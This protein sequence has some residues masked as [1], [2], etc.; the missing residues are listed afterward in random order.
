LI[1][2]WIIAVVVSVVI[3]ALAGFLGGFFG[4]GGGVIL[5]PA[6]LWLFGW[7]DPAA[8]STIKE[9]IGTSLFLVIPAGLGAVRK[10]RAL[11]NLELRFCTRWA[12]Y[13][14]VGAV[15]GIGLSLLFHPG[16]IKTIFTVYLLLCVI[17]MLVLKEKPGHRSGFPG[18]Q[19]QIWGGVVIGA[20]SVLLGVGGGAFVTPYFKLHGCALKKAIGISSATTVVVGL[21]GTIGM[22]ITGWDAPGRVPYSLGYVSVI[23]AVLV[24]P[25]MFVMSPYGVAAAHRI[26]KSWLKAL[27][28]IFLMLLFGYMVWHT[29]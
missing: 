5:V 15:C 29:Y 22:I 24:G 27:Y 28:V 2:T 19:G 14:A 23:V 25:L 3:G 20:L 13:I 8:G 12:I 7:V 16:L 17:I 26:S 4:I 11:G 6:F 18:Q 10:Q 1:E 21:V 9:A